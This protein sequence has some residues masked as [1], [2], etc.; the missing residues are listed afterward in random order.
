M[1]AVWAEL[2]LSAADEFR[3]GNVPAIK[4]PLRVAQRAFQ[5]LPETVAEYRFRGD[6]ACYEQELLS[7][8]RNEKREDG[9]QGFIGFAVS[10]PMQAALLEEIRAV[11][12]GEWQLYSEDTE[13]VKHCAHVKYFP[14]E[15]AEN[16]FRT[17]LKYIA[18]RIRKKQQ[19]LFADGASVKYFA[20]ATNLWDWDVGRLLRWH[21]EKAGTIEAVHDC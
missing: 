5:A 7:W 18:I 19:E 21:R 1:L 13:A 3:D 17:P 8:L 6:S 9:P 12:E 16:E 14:E 11:A 15:R 20:V 2:D 10:A 4:E